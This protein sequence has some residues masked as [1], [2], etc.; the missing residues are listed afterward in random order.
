MTFNASTML[1]PRNEQFHTKNDPHVRENVEFVTKA[2]ETI[3]KEISIKPKEEE[4]QLLNNN[5]K[6]HRK[7]NNIVWL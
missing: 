1:S 2:S 5:K 3:E 6:M 4:V 7:S